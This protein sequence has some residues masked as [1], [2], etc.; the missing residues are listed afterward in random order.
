[1]SEEILRLRK[2]MKNAFQ[3]HCET[4][5]K[6]KFHVFNHIVEDVGRFGSRNTFVA[7]PFELMMF[8]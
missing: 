5:L 7:L 6:L 8:I 3:V 4:G 1:M 2:F